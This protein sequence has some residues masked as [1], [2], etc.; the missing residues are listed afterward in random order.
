MRFDI[1]ELS[2]CVV[3][4]QRVQIFL[5]EAV[6]CDIWWGILW[7][8]KGNKTI[9]YES[10]T[11]NIWSIKHIS[12]SGDKMLNMMGWYKVARVT[13]SSK[14]E[15]R[16]Y[17]DLLIIKHIPVWGVIKC[18]VWWGNILLEG[19]YWKRQ[20][21]CSFA[22]YSVTLVPPPW[23]CFASTLRKGCCFLKLTEQVINHLEQ[24]EEEGG[25]RVSPGSEYDCKD[26]DGWSVWKSLIDDDDGIWFKSLP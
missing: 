3:V 7:S 18:V 8:I 2:S 6:K 9:N 1:K 19:K 25:R 13:K 5:F 4:A 22:M 12:L 14:V 10:I 23:I 16:T 17:V 26:E 15:V 20:S 11:L 21:S 24:D